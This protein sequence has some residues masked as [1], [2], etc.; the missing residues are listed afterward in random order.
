MVYSTCSMNPIENE[1]VVA[2]VLDYLFTFNDFFS[3]T[4]K[5]MLCTVLRSS[6]MP[7]TLRKWNY[8]HV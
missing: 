5:T 6:P 7:L 2:E 1:A 4:G 8:F 3:G